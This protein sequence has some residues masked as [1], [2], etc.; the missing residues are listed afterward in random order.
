MNDT[1]NSVVKLNR[2]T[3]YIVLN[4]KSSTDD[5]RVSEE[6]Q[7]N[8]WTVWEP[9]RGLRRIHTTR[10]FPEVQV[11]IIRVVTRDLRVAAIIKTQ[12]LA[13][14]IKMLAAY[15]HFFIHALVHSFIRSYLI[16]I[17]CRIA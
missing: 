1:R 6:I 13:V 12:L 4:W 8:N 7:L 10:S 15:I 5:G 14:I 11:L 2:L 17:Q 9:Q 16:I 3:D